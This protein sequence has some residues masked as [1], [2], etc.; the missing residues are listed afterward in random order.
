MPQQLAQRHD[1]DLEIG[2]RIGVRRDT[3]RLRTHAGAPER[4]RRQRWWSP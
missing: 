3:R 4:A 2:Q 1:L